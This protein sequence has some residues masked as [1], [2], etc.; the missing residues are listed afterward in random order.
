MFKKICQ[1]LKAYK[2][3]GQASKLITDWRKHVPTND[4]ETVAVG[5]KSSWASKINWNSAVMLLIG[6]AG[7]FGYKISDTDQ[8]TIMAAI[9]AVGSVVTIII[10]TF[11]TTS[12]TKSSA[13]KKNG[14]T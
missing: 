6:V 5:V 2:L 4:Q 3:W 9:M 13:A 12:L 14:T 11:F 8:E 10:R 1:M 7:F